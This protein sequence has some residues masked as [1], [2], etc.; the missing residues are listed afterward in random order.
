[1]S[2]LTAQHAVV[3]QPERFSALVLLGAVHAP[4]EARP[5]GLRERA[6]RSAHRA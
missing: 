5:A 4:A 3:R 6:A 1:M 2:T